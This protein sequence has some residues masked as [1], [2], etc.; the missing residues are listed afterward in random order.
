MSAIMKLPVLSLCLLATAAAAPLA[1]A[2]TPMDPLDARDA[3]RLDK[4]EQV[5]RELRSIVFQ[6]R[7]IGKPVVV[8]PAETDYQLQEVSRR[9]VDL[10]QTITRMTGDLENAN[11]QAELAKRDAEALRTENRSLSDRIASL[12]SRA[13]AETVAPPGGL[14]GASSGLSAN[15]LFS[16][17]RQALTSGDYAAAESGFREYVDAYGD[18]SKAAEARYWLGKALTARNAHADAAGSYIAAIR[19][20]PST[21]WAPDAVV[22][23]SRSLIALKKPADACQTLAEF[24]KRYPKASTTVK[25]RAAQARNQAKCAA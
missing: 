10:E 5:V 13:L 24:A 21:S 12:E 4:M 17:A 6:G 1:F 16:E 3:R 2:Q 11:R 23:L 20:W 14:G 19:G 9:L 18:S 15:D 7:D 25:T 8:Q 22:E